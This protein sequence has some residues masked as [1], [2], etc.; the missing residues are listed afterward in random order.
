MRCRSFY[1]FTILTTTYIGNRLLRIRKYEKN[2]QIKTTNLHCLILLKD[3]Q[4]SLIVEIFFDPIKN[5]KK[6]GKF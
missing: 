1:K 6:I 3:G 5:R 2:E 4:F